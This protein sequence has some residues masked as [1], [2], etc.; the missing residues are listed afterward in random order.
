MGPQW[1]EKETRF[2]LDPP[3]MPAV[4]G[5]LYKISVSEATGF[6]PQ[7]FPDPDRKEKKRKK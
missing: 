1:E 5:D 4:D 6:L 2:S 7:A 3:L